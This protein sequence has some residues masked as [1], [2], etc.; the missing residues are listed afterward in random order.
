MTTDSFIT[1]GKLTTVTIN[2][3]Q[4]VF[5]G[6]ILVESDTDY[7]KARKVWNGMIDRRPAIIAQCLCIN[8]I[9]QAVKF[10]RKYNLLVS[11]KGGGHNVTGNAVCDDGIMIDLSLMRSIRVD[12]ENQVA[13]VQPGATWGDFDN[14]TQQH[15]LAS[16]GGLISTTGVAGLTLG[17][18]VGW[19]V[20]KHGLSCDNLIE[21]EIVTAEGELLKVNTEENAELF[22][23]IR[24]GG[25]N[26]GVIASMKFRVHKLDK[27]TGGMILHPHTKA[28]EVIQFYREFM[29]TA[30]DELTLYTCLMTTPDGFPVIAFVGCYSGDPGKAEAVLKPLREFGSPL[31]DLM[32]PKSYIEMQ[33]MLDAPFPH[34]NRYYWKSGF[35]ETLSD[36]AIDIIV[37]NA[38]SVTSPYSA[39]ILEYYGGVSSHEPEGGTSYPHRQA[40]FDLVLISN[41]VDREEDEKNIN[42]TR[43]FYEAMQVYSSHRVY[44]NALGIEGEE[45]VKEAY[46]ESYQ[47]LTALKTKY[48]PENLFRMNQN[49]SPV[50]AGM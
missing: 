44:V 42:W 30:P 46:G 11:V 8:D 48:D 31:A 2:E 19:L 43:K 22:W 6:K 23:G 38:A 4:Q 50:Q 33:T 1:S 24:G 49:I 32:Q 47:R 17:G 27:V 28:K 16:T 45:R 36:E 21:A 29:K 39:I 3:L 18:G 9:V 7:E 26:F 25:G 13:E 35:L 41:W 20:R 12:P 37:S 14:A 5:E 34:G 10:A 40:E 15:G